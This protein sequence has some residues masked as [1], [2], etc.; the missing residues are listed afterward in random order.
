MS[1]KS[2]YNLDTEIGLDK[3][4]KLP[5]WKQGII[6]SRKFASLGYQ[7]VYNER[8]RLGY[9]TIPS[10]HCVEREDKICELTLVRSGYLHDFYDIKA[11]IKEYKAIFIAR[12]SERCPNMLK[13]LPDIPLN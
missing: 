2:E 10:P 4:S 9:L 1:N 12:Y 3:L 6:L 11:S 7:F 13:Y 5:K 8:T